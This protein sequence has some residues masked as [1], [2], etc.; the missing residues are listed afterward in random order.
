VALDWHFLVDEDSGPKLTRKQLREALREANYNAQPGTISLLLRL[1]RA[2][3]TLGA[4]ERS[5][6]RSKRLTLPFLRTVVRK[7]QRPDQ[8]LSAL[9]AQIETPPVDGRKARRRG[10]V[11]GGAHRRVNAVTITWDAGLARS[12]PSEY[13]RRVLE[14]IRDVERMVVPRLRSAIVHHVT[15]LHVSGA[16]TAELYRSMRAEGGVLRTTVP[17]ADWPAPLREADTALATFSAFVR[18]MATTPASGAARARAMPLVEPL[19]PDEIDADL[20]E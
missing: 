2:L 7:G 6:Y 14:Q 11:A 20:A 18:S 16:W 19:R 12:D 17:A 8:I 1:G 5:L 3:A 4:V 9:Q 10:G 13:T 15:R